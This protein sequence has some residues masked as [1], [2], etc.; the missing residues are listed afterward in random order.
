MS[1]SSVYELHITPE[2][3]NPDTTRGFIE[4]CKDAGVKA[5]VV[6][7]G[8]DKVSEHLMTSYIAHG[9]DAL[10]KAYQ[11]IRGIAKDLGLG[12]LRTKIEVP[13]TVP[14]DYVAGDYYYEAHFEVEVAKDQELVFDPDILSVS[15]R[16]DKITG[17]DTC[18][19]L[20]T[21]RKRNITLAEFKSFSQD[22]VDKLRTQY[23]DVGSYHVEKCI[24]DDNAQ[25]DADW[26][27]HP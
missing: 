3:K 27:R 24:A 10:Q 16:A 5:F 1:S 11:T 7:N 17:S 9:D 18:P 6:A 8:K 23:A 2:M 4:R 15:S 20:F 14:G 19:F 12:I 21:I 26:M 22:T 25:L 13:A